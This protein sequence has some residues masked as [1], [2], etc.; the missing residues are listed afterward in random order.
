LMV[1]PPTSSI[2]LIIPIVYC[3]K[4]DTVKPRWN[5]YHVL[6]I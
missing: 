3:L 6:Q 1:M 4:S 5:Q 2:F